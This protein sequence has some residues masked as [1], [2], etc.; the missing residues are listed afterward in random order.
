MG[1]AGVER[2]HARVT[3]TIASVGSTMAGC[4]HHVARMTYIHFR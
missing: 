3:R 2:V 1:I 4:V